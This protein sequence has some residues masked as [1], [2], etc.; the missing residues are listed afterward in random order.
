MYIAFLKKYRYG[1]A[2]CPL[3]PNH[4]EYQKQNLKSKSMQHTKRLSK[5]Y[6]FY[7]EFECHGNK[8]QLFN[9]SIFCNWK[10][11]WKCKVLG[12]VAVGYFQ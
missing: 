7:I 6:I 2:P 3:E 11:Q 10:Y 12:W 4:P 1:I 5:I 8:I 9:M